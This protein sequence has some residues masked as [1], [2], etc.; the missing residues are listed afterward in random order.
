MPFHQ[1]CIYLALIQKLVL[2]D[3]S[4]EYLN[5]PREHDIVSRS[6]QG[7]SGNSRYDRTQLL[8]RSILFTLV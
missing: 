6:S 4:L 1:I 8:L 2:E 5:Y 7:P 3:A